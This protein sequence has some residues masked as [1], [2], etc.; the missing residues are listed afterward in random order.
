MNAYMYIFLQYSLFTCMTTSYFFI[1]ELGNENG[2][3]L[4]IQ[5]TYTDSIDSQI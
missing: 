5:F 3:L 4:S 1:K 2:I